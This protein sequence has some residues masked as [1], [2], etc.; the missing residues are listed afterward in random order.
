[1]Q[2]KCGAE[3]S[4][5]QHEV[6]TMA[7]ASEWFAEVKESQLPIIVGQD[8]CPGCGRIAYGITSESAR[9]EVLYRQG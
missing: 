5:Q 1:M 4:Y 2:C 3:T 9:T 8:K 7:K 6:K